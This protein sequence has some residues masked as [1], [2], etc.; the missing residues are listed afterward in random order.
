MMMFIR[1]T[2]TQRLVRKT[3]QLL[4]EQGEGQDHAAG[5]QSKPHQAKLV[6]R[7]PKQ[8]LSSLQLH[9]QCPASNHP[10]QALK[11]T[12]KLPHHLL[13]RCLSSSP[14]T[15]AAGQL[16]SVSTAFNTDIKDVLMMKVGQDM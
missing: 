14:P 2:S 8:S 12:S 9:Q 6:P 3:N 4:P 16:N 7:I 15:G 10:H 1:H 13:R 11:V 5:G